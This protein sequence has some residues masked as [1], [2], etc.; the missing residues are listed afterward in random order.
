M[1]IDQKFIDLINAD[2]DGEISDVEMSELTAFLA[3][4]PEGRAQ[5]EHLSM[6]CE[7]LDSVEHVSPPVHLRHVIMNSIKPAKPEQESP[8]ILQILFAVP[9]LRYGLTFAAGVFL[10]LSLVN[11]VQLS[12][13]ALDDVT[14]LVG[15]MSDPIAADIV[16]SIAVDSVE[17]AGTVSLRNSGPM[18]ILDFD[19]T[20]QGPL[21]I[22]A[23]YTD[24]TIWFNGF[25]QLESSG[26]T[27]SAENGHIRLGMDGKRRYAVYLHNEG[28]RGTTVSLRFIAGGKI[29]HEAS[30]VYEPAE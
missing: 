1:A 8:G 28:R 10:T 11:S 27:I 2:I 25:G 14:G 6:L 5:H 17:V 26:T 29:V 18:L 4:S 22:Q 23:D 24:R 13:S 21:E 3:D 30:L 7:S 20:T 16:S 19:L 15:T 9:T 12:N